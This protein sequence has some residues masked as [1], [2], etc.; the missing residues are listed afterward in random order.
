MRISEIKT[1][2]QMRNEKREMIDLRE[3]QCK[4]NNGGCW[5]GEQQW[6][7]DAGEPR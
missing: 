3:S 4:S 7:V 5:M 2:N 6:A 1:T